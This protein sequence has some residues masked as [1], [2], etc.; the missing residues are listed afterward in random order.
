[1]HHRD[2][3]VNQN[4]TQNSA[5]KSRTE[6]RPPHRSPKRRPG[7]HK[8]TPHEQAENTE[9]T[10]L[11]RCQSRKCLLCSKRFWS[12][13]SK[14]HILSRLLLKLVLDTFHC[15][16]PPIGI[17]TPRSGENTFSD[18]IAYNF[19]SCEKDYIAVLDLNKT[20]V[21]RGRN[22]KFIDGFR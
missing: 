17:F 6:S 12:G 16:I 1:M 19:R 13:L 4:P 18:C 14:C 2:I 11:D 3:T 22:L 10:L 20:V 5:S 21:P 15:E 7:P 9:G 8:P